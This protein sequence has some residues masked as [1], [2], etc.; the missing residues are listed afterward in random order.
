MTLQRI[1]PKRKPTVVGKKLTQMMVFKYNDASLLVF[2]MSVVLA[3]LSSSLN[4]ALYLWRMKE[5]RNEVK[6]LVN[7][8]LC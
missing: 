6:R 7:K 1:K 5:I 3:F 2:N 8:I 4:P